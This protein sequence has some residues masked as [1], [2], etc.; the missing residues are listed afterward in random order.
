MLFYLF[1]PAEAVRGIKDGDCILYNNFLSVINAEQLSA[2]LNE[3]FEK[4]GH[5]KDL[6]LYCTAGLGG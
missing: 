5:P 1:D 6:T 4:E 2:A 3:R